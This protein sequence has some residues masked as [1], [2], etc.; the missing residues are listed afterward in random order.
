MPSKAT[1]AYREVT[2]PITEPVTKFGGQPVWMEDPCWPL[3]REYGTPMQF[4]C[5]IALAP[6]LFGGLEA[7]MAYLFVTDDFAHGYMAETWEQ[8]GGENAVIL[9]PGGIWNGPTAPL[10]EGPSLYRRTWTGVGFDPETGAGW[11]RT[12]CEFAVELHL[13]ADPEAGA[14]DH[15]DP[16][17][18][19]TWDAYMAALFEDK[20]GGTPVPTVNKPKFPDPQSW[21]LLLQLNT[22]ENEA[23]DPFFLNFADDGVGYAFISQD[24][25]QGTFLWSR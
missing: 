21:R 17:D 3:S 1:I 16:D 4:V 2:S 8:E 10:R 20:L 18:T 19:P 12:P 9:Q 24:G 7:R 25:R 14:W 15:V 13:G 6:K 22:K 23:G 5:Q 11:E